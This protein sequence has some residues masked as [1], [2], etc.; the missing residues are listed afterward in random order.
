MNTKDLIFHTAKRLFY[1]NGFHDTT[2]R[3]LAKA[4]GIV[5]SNLF[6]HYDSMNDIALQIMQE[7]VETS[8][9][10]V[11]ECEDDLTPIE[12]YISYTIVD[13]YYMYYD[14]KFAELCF[15]IPEILSD[16]IYDNAVKEIFPELN[17]ASGSEDKQRIYAYLDLQAVIT[18]QI[19]TTSLVKNRNLNLNIN[20]VIEYIL[21][22]KKRIWNIDDK[23]FN[24]A[25][26]RSEQ[27]VR[28]VDYSKLNIFIQ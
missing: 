18:T 21:Q 14:R 10:I 22:L 15:E 9:K 5:H 28:A 26:Q 7:F 17:L 11:L 6:Y 4:C 16:A 25:R 19:K 1:N 20:Q 13:I 23:T 8:R 24:H 27:I 12:L 3:A 2:A